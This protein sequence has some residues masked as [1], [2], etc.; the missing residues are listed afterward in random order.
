MRLLARAVTPPDMPRRFDTWFFML[1]K[2]AI[3]HVP[4]SGFQ[5]SGELEN[6]QWITPEEAI[7]KNTREITRVILVEL[8]NR[9]RDD[10]ALD[11]GY[12]APAYRTIRNRFQ[13]TH[14]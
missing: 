11:P 9:L 8:M 2:N 3:A 5:P 4:T 13:R 7:T 12:T 10:P 1:E 6:L 14:M